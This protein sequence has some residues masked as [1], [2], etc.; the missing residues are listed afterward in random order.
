MVPRSVT[1]TRVTF[2]PSSWLVSEDS[3]KSAADHMADYMPEHR[4]DGACDRHDKPNSL[5]LGH[6]RFADFPNLQSY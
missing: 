3:S 4:K 6:D 2:W 1:L 5:G